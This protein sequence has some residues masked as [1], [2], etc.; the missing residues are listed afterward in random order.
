MRLGLVILSPFSTL[1]N[2]QHLNQA[3]VS[4]GDTADVYFQLVDMDTIS[5]RFQRG[6][7]YM[8]ASGATMQVTMKSIN[9]ANTV[10]KAAT[11]AFPSDDRSIWKFSLS[12][13]ETQKVAGVNLRIV[14]T[15]GS[16]IKSAN[17]TNVISVTPAN[18]FQC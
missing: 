5:E 1:N 7:R 15:E 16:N 12:A 3:S 11:M 9:D 17:A 10:A 13:A 2:L 14:L 4:Q 8:P 6:I 18:Q